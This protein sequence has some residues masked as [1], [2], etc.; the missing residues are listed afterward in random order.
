[1]IRLLVV[2]D[3]LP[4]QK[5]TIKQLELGDVIQIVGSATTSDEALQAAQK[6]LPDIVLLDLHLPGLISTIDLIKRMIALRNV[7]V[8]AFASQSK[9][10]DVQDL[11]DAGASAYILKND[12]PMLVRMAIV[13][14]SR[15]AR[16]VTTPSLPYQLTR[17]TAQERNILSQA[18]GRGPISKAALRLGISEAELNESLTQLAEKLELAD[19]DKLIKWA[20]K[21]GF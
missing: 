16:S 18:A 3:D 10:A 13:M 17:F 8:V 21:Q 11:L 9:A 6:L 5:E 12:S 7:K 14:V 1:M 4:T 19:V 15:G 2:D 20:K